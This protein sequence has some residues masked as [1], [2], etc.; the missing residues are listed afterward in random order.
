MSH[1]NYV[2]PKCLARG[3]Q[4]GYDWPTVVQTTDSKVRAVYIPRDEPLRRVRGR[5]VAMPASEMEDLSVLH[6][7]C[8]G[9]AHSFDYLDPR[10]DR[11]SAFGTDPTATDCPVGTADGIETDFPVKKEYTIG[12]TD[13]YKTIQRPITS[14]I[15]VAVG[16]TPQGSGWSWVADEFLIRFT[17]AP[18]TGTVTIGC[19][20]Y[21]P[22]TFVNTSLL[23]TIE[24]YDGS[25]ILL[26]ASLEL[27]EVILKGSD[28]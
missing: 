23:Q 12:T 6:Y 17:V 27:E 10:D 13:R 14:S 1:L 15:L 20:F 5:T 16:G 4:A 28:I 21:Y 18:V 11:T 19:R 2:F 8:Q 7:V 25:E 22:M 3:E 9:A 24:N 26:S